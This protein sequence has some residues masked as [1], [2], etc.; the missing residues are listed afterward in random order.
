MRW[1]PPAFWHAPGGAETPAA[2]LLR[3]A[4]CAYDAVS[5]R[6]FERTAPFRAAA[7]VVCTGNVTLGGV[8]KTPFT[9][10]LARLAR[11]AG[12]R[13]HVLTRGYGGTAKGPLRVEPR[14]AAREVGD[15]ALMLSAALPVWVGADRALSAQA[16]TEAGASLLLMDDGFQ[17]AGLAKDASFLLIDAAAGFGNGAV[18]PAGPLREA[19]ARAFARADAAVLVGEGEGPAMPPGLPC[20]RCGLAL[21]EEAVPRGPLLAFAGIGRPERFFGAVAAAGGEVAEARAFP[22]H[23]P[24]TQR[25]LGSLREEAARQ[26]AT[27]VTTEKDFARLPAGERDGVTPLPAAMRSED[28]A[29]I[30]ALLLSAAGPAP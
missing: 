18:F 27:L 21:D 9:A 14:H 10:M 6:R 30:A 3:P 20:F 1:Q 17:N 28:E 25:E 26:G 4:A 19:P 24:Y 16:A 5:R 15:E 12:H 2:R 8:G 13:P 22:D 11:E 29:A 7:P 23:H